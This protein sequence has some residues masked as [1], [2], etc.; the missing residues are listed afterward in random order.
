[1]PSRLEWDRQDRERLAQGAKRVSVHDK[2]LAALDARREAIIAE[3]II[4]KGMRDEESNRL[5]S[6]LESTTDETH[7]W[8]VKKFGS[9]L[10]QR[11][12]LVK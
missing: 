8:F 12:P 7:D 3:M 1:M 6:A 5:R 11:S 2:Q 4:V 10:T 9:K